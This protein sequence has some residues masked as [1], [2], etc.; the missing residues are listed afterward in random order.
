MRAGTGLSPLRAGSNVNWR[1]ASSAAAS[2]SAPADATTFASVNVPSAAIVSSSSIAAPSAGV[3][4][5]RCRR[6]ELRHAR[7]RQRGRLRRVRGVCANARGAIVV[8]LVSSATSAL[9]ISFHLFVF[10]PDISA[11]ARSFSE[12]RASAHH[13]ETMPPSAAVRVVDG[14][15]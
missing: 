14:G 15:A 2:S 8:P 9:A 4:S 6:D 3:L 13:R 10:A 7:R 12:S 1:T 11:S 5:G